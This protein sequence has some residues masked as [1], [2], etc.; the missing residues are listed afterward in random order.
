MILFE[1][2]LLTQ[3]RNNL[4]LQSK[5]HEKIVLKMFFFYFSEH[6]LEVINVLEPGISKSK[7]R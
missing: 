4:H 6:L 1:N 2:H 7:A 5:I 3:V